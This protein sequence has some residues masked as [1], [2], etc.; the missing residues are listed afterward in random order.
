MS[1]YLQIKT[2]FVIFLWSIDTKARKMNSINCRL[3]VVFLAFDVFFMI[4][5]IAMACI[6]FFLLFCCFPILATVAYAMTI[7]DGA[8]ESDIRSLP[9]YLYRQQNTVGSFDDGNKEVNLRVIPGN[10]NSTPELVLQPEDSVSIYYIYPLVVLTTFYFTSDHL[11][12]FSSVFLYVQISRF[13][14]SEGLL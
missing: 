7:R 10:S 3:S 12:S 9:K 11:L 8:S 4:F 2:V 1:T 14:K 6:I 13:W 5:C